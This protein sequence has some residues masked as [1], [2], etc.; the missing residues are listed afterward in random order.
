MTQASAA[1]TERRLNGQ[2]TA[3]PIEG[4]AFPMPPQGMMSEQVNLID[5]GLVLGLVHPEGSPILIV[6]WDGERFRRL[7]PD[8]ANTWATEIALTPGLGP[9]LEAIRKLVKRAG[10]IAVASLMRTEGNA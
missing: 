8:Q 9:V 3:P 7:L 5:F 10:D 2:H 6:V 1:R 4:R